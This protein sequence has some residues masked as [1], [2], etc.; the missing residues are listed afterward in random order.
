MKGCMRTMITL[1]L[2]TSCLLLIA[3]IVLTCLNTSIAGDSPFTA[4]SNARISVEIDKNTGAL[5]SI[6][7]NEQQITYI[8][9]GVGFKVIT[10]LGS[11][12][13]E[14]RP[15]A[16]KK[17]D[18]LSLLYSGKVFEI[19][20]HYRLGKDD[21]FIEKWLDIKCKDGRPYLLKE[22]ILEDTA[23]SSQ[24]KDIF[25]HDDKTIWHCPINLFMRSGKGGLYSG[26][27]Y[28]W[29]TLDIRGNTGFKLGY[30]PQYQVSL[31]EVN[32]S[33]KYFLGVFRREGIYRY[34]HGPYPG[35]IPAAF[36]NWDHTGLY[37]HF[38]DGRIPEQPVDSEILDWGEVWAMQEFMRH[39]LPELPLPE[40]GYWV[41]Q[42]GWWAGLFNPERGQ[43]DQL[44]AAGVHDVMTANTWYGRG[45]HPNPEPYLA[46][47]RIEPPGFPVAA[48]P[49]SE[50]GTDDSRKNWHTTA[51]PGYEYDNPIEFTS[52]FTAPKVFE[53]YITY[54]REIG[55]HVNS[56]SLPSI[57]FNNKPE[58]GAIGEDGK[59][60]EYLFGRKA[61]CAASDEYMHYMLDLY[62][63]VFDK[64]QP[65]WWGWDG[66][67]LNYWEV[68]LYRPGTSTT[69]HDPC[70]ATNHRHLPGESSY[71]EW[72][73]ILQ[74]HSQIRQ[75]YPKMCLEAYLG[76]K[77]GGPWA[78]RYLN[79]DDNYFETNGA[80]M[81]RMQCWHNQN[82]RFRPV[83]KNY[84]ALFGDD[85][86]GFQFSLLSTISA[87]SYCQIGPGFIGLAREENREFLKKWRS[88]GSAN[89][90]YLKVKR[91]MFDCPGYSPVDGSAHIIKDKG[92]IFLFPAGAFS[93][94]AE[95]RK[96][97]ESRTQVVMASI[98]ISRWIGL[99]TNEGGIYEITEIYPK[100]GR[101]L[102]AYRYGDE[103]IYQMPNDSA[104][105]LSLEPTE[106]MPSTVQ[107]PLSNGRDLLLVSAF[108][109]R[110]TASAA[111]RSP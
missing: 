24:I 99:R 61:S 31:N 28:P 70:Y 94:D 62:F 49:K 32:T 47:M 17:G 60:C 13:P 12:A 40:G 33:E 72:R 57:W 74:F 50:V 93:P 6:R 64:Y 111:T 75:R 25:L 87:S 79:C 37:Q 51:D 22:V 67:W 46:N 96:R 100:K 11:F 80:D 14:G 101:V 27:E 102:G 8:L 29:W 83:S 26:L 98:P 109:N 30:S 97:I 89:L 45:N 34:S 48:G 76:L 56:F 78:L 15:K 43:L 21:A 81:N 103:F 107:V 55:M 4:M 58:W 2:S 35:K 16:V 54:A 18:T 88:W 9:R 38:R 65:R 77:R 68:M 104:V 3:V 53:D 69:N 105:V 23:V 85:P 44:K 39:V 92:F 59:P 82:D 36:V 52:G 19:T 5:R 7:D 84:A 71:K 73:N 42:N 95:I 106:S 91:D 1:N 41:W 10:D 63:H 86:A 20:L 90:K 108:S 110:V 66:R